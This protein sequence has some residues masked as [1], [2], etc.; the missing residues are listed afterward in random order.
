MGATPSRPES[1]G[2]WRNIAPSDSAA[3]I[4]IVGVALP[5]HRFYGH[6]CPEK[7]AICRRFYR[8]RVDKFVARLFFGGYSPVR[9]ALL[10][11]CC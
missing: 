2:H 3:V 7:A 8:L 10:N 4:C 1:T 5:G 9:Q 6:F 11:A